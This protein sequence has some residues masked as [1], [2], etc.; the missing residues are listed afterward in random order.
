MRQTG[1]P[2][3]FQNGH[4]QGQENDEARM[5]K[6]EG[7]PNAQM[8]RGRART[9][10]RASDFAFLRHSS[11]VLRH[12]QCVGARPK[13]YR[14]HLPPINL[15][16]ARFVRRRC[17]SGY[18]AERNARFL[19]GSGLAFCAVR[20][21]KAAHLFSSS[22]IWRAS[23]A[24]PIPEIGVVRRNSASHVSKATLLLGIMQSFVFTVWS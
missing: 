23:S 1:S 8:T 18:A 17:R 16:I 4:A 11:F 13:T 9:S 10:L 7:N 15:W 12:W 22:A 6:H 5:S 2:A 14:D 3:G 21:R 24:T 20:R 19:R